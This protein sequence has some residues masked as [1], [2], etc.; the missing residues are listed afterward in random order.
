[1]ELEIVYQPS[2]EEPSQQA[3]YVL[4]FGYLR[5]KIH[6]FF[7]SGTELPYTDVRGKH[8]GLLSYV[9][10]WTRASLP[11]LGMRMTLFLATIVRM[12]HLPRVV[13]PAICSWMLVSGLGKRE[14]HWARDVLTLGR[15]SGNNEKTC[16]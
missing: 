9:V 11:S 13:I 4:S 3:R 6:C 12:M 15:Q 16:L 2:W 10:M 8:A 5:N 14:G 7:G 1:M